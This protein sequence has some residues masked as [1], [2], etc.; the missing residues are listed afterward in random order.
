MACIGMCGTPFFITISF[1]VEIEVI[2]S[3]SLIS[4]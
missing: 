4:H 2:C 1:S 3:G